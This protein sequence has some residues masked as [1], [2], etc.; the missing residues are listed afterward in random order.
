MALLAWGLALALLGGALGQGA[1][2]PA[3]PTAWGDRIYPQL[4]QAGL[5]VTH[6]DVALR[7][8]QPGTRTLQAEVTLTVQA[9]RPLPLLSLD[10]LGPAVQGVTWNGAAVRYERAAGKLLIRRALAPG[11]PARVTVR[12]AGPAGR[13]PDPDLPVDLGWQAL[14]GQGTQ[15]GVNFTFSEPDGTRAFLPVNDHPGDPAAFT[16]RVTVPRGSPPPPV[17]GR[18]LCRTRPRAAPSPS[19]SASRFP[20]TPWPFTLGRWSAWIAR[21][22]RWG[23]GGGPARLLPTRYSGEHP[24]ALRAHRRDSASSGR[25]VRPL[26]LCHLRLGGGHAASARAGNSHAVHHAGHLQQRARDRA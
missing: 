19:S 8:P 18:P 24:R 10:Y 4:G 13:V 22:C 5:D 21:R 26:P 16:L 23:Q 2:A 11:T 12:L 25:V 9:T 3:V 6:Y 15:P 20:L 14:P 17:A 7:V 1:L